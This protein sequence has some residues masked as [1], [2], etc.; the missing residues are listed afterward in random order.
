MAK[1]KQ[2]LSV[3][4]DEAALFR[5]ISEII[6]NRKIRAGAYANREIALMYWEVGR[7]Y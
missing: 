2:E 3:Q 5:R 7:T 6:E 4:I 1:K